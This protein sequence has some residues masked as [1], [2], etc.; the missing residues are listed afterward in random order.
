[1]SHVNNTRN[2]QE[3]SASTDLFLTLGRLQLQ[4]GASEDWDKVATVGEQVHGAGGN[5]CEPVLSAMEN[6]LAVRLK[7]L[8]NAAS[9]ELLILYVLNDHQIFCYLA[10]LHCSFVYVVFKSRPRN[11]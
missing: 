7:K 5:G 2:A 4:H 10:V 1:M 8:Q 6:A 3:W 9:A 11:G